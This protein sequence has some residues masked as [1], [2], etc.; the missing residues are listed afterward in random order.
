[1]TW[2]HEKEKCG[3]PVNHAF[4]LEKC[5][6]PVNHAFIIEK[7]EKTGNFKRKKCRM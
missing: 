6:N 7:A 5:G 1:M 2:I 4:I 3:N